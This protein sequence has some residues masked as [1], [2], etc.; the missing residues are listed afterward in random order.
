[1]SR[2]DSHFDDH[3]D[4]MT[5]LLYLEAELD[6]SREREVTDHLS[7]C[8][9]CRRLLQALQR[10]NIWL[11]ESLAAQEE[12]IPARLSR[13]PGATSM[14]WAPW[15]WIT[16][17]G[18]GAGGA[19]TLWSGVVDPWLTQA[20]EA[21]FTQGNLLTMLL[22]S[23][24][25]WKGWDAMQSL[26][27]FL[28]V[29]TL[30]V[31]FLWVAR[32]HWGRFSVAG[33]V[34][35][36]GLAMLALPSP[37]SAT[38]VVHGDPNYTLAAGQEVKTDLIVA[39]QHV[40][41]DGD[42]D[43]DL[44][45]WSRSITVNGH[46]KGDILAFG[47]ELRVNG[48]VDGN[49]RAFA[50][51][52]TLN[53]T[54]AKNV[55]TWAREFDMDEKART[56]GTMTLG[57]ADVQLDGHVN[58]DLLAFVEDLDING[59]LDH[60]ATIRA[61]R[62]RIGPNAAIAGHTQYRGGRQPEMASG[63]RMGS[64]VEIIE[65]RRPTPRYASPRMYWHQI[66][67]WGASLLFGVL[68]LL[69][70]PAF[71]ADTESATK[72]FGP[73]IGLGLLFLLAIPVAAILACITIVGLGVGIA[74]IL[75]YIVALYSTQVFVGA[76]LGEKLMGSGI[77]TGAMI[78]RLAIGLAILRLLRLIPFAGHLVGLIVVLWGL[79]ALV[80]AIH[81]RIRPQFAPA[82]V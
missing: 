47:Q 30:G 45:V 74:T 61:Q 24:A 53:G 34:L 29:A 78:A 7:A 3:F 68:M 36:A 81:K 66:L 13:A 80:L 31:F 79:G 77:G 6:A 51:S 75:V 43:G 37:A 54:V 27:Q 39:A 25:F 16:A 19:Y 11:R 40:R 72:R 35:G 22:F 65:R 15:T 33:I 32:R 38:D 67:A 17:L 82:T 48:P 50:Q 42:V 55:M 64:P 57:S 8:A 41:I 70:A 20:S 76:W 56:G 28:A 9:E 23:G 5:G 21:G 18:M 60:D 69:V 63:A 44:I 62:L 46:V 10:E 4:E 58:G 14:P 26:V 1:M 52:F 59:S 71:F 12:A 73:A 49:V 2:F